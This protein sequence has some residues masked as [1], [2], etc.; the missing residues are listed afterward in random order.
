MR[1]LNVERIVANKYNHLLTV[2]IVSIFLAP[3]FEQDVRIPGLGLV[4]MML[5]L[6]IVLCLRATVSSKRVF[7]A[8]VGILILGTLLD[9]ISRQVKTVELA[10]T[11]SNINLLLD[12]V[13]T[14]WA[15]ILL[16]KSMFRASRV[17]ADTIVGGICVY[18]LIGLLWAV[19]YILLNNLKSGVIA[20]E[21]DPSLF[22]FS[23]TTLTTL[24]YG[25]IVPKGKYVMMLASFEAISG[26]TFLA[27]FI[28]RLVGLHT[29]QG[30]RLT[31][32]PV[33]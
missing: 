24:G 8:C 33:E 29:A 5:L 31:E 23:F 18:L 26:Q 30:F 16:M 15:I 19:V 21:G 22:Y 4:S 3:A 14:A 11:L 32:E 17:T 7:W 27:V 13:F 12:A 28:A 10:D 20:F 1:I 6:T 2:L 9:I 25:D